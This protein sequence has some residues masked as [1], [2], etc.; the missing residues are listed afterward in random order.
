LC[1]LPMNAFY[2]YCPWLLYAPPYSIVLRTGGSTATV[3]ALHADLKKL[4]AAAEALREEVGY[5]T[6]RADL[7][8]ATLVR[9]TQHAGYC[10][11]VR[12]CAVNSPHP[13][14]THWQ[15][16][17]KRQLHDA[18]SLLQSARPG[19]TH[20]NGQPMDEEEEQDGFASA[21]PWMEPTQASLMSVSLSQVSGVYVRVALPGEWCL[22]PCRS[23]R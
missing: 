20:V 1:M 17:M 6:E 3:H 4:R 15:I 2:S 10:G 23:P 7:A 5:Q 16:R 8:E 22:C 11:Q 12:T 18:R 19:T 14:H 13:I 9:R 21:A